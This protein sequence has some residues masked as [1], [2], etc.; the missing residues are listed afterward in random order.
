MKYTTCMIMCVVLG[1]QWWRVV[2]LQHRKSVPS[3]H[4]CLCACRTSTGP[5]AVLSS[6]SHYQRSVSSLNQNSVLLYQNLMYNVERKL[7]TGTWCVSQA[8][9]VNWA[10]VLQT[11]CHCYCS[12]TKRNFTCLQRNPAR[13]GASSI[14][15]L[16]AVLQCSKTVI[17][18]QLGVKLNVPSTY[19]M[20]QIKMTKVPYLCSM[21]MG[22]DQEKL[23][24]TLYNRDIPLFSLQTSDLSSPDLSRDIFVIYTYKHK[25]IRQ[26]CH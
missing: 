6:N 20:Y 2:G 7:T 3:L 12:P 1:L 10:F 18:V 25:N 14:V 23:K 19:Y 22:H 9:D 8:Q 15:Y 16:M 11:I 4:S 13:Y 5:W 26:L 24:L 17:C 21:C